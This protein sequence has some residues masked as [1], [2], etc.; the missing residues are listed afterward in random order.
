MIVVCNSGSLIALGK[1]NLLILLKKL[2]GTIY[3]PESVYH[4]VVTSGIRRG[5]L[6]SLN[7]KLFVERY[8][9]VIDVKKVHQPENIELGKGESDAIGFALEINGD[10][11]LIDEELARTEA[12]RVGVKVKG[13]LGILLEAYRKDILLL[14]DLEYTIEQIKVRK[15]IW[16]SRKL[17][18]DVLEKIRDMSR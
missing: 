17:C 9:D 3:I 10:F 7:I 15:D 8:G 2:Y 12:R 14:E 11:V 1:L 13:T 4:E 6:D 5:K 18:D 16:V